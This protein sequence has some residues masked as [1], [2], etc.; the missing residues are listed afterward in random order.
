MKRSTIILILLFAALGAGTWFA[1]RY[2]QKA[3]QGSHIDPDMDFAIKNTDEIYKIFIADRTGRT[4]TLE[5][6][7]SKWLYNKAYIARQTAVDQLLETM[8]K[9]RVNYIPPAASEPGMIKSIAA[10]GIKVEAYDKEGKI[11]KVYYVGGVTNDE[12]GTYVMMEGAEHP[13]VA[14]IPI[15]VGSFRIHFRLEPDE[16]YDR[17]IFEEKPED[18]QFVSVEYPQR[19]SES[20]KLEKKA[21]LEYVVTP[22]FSTTPV[23][24][25]PQKKGTAEA[26]LI[27]FEKLGCEAY[28][29]HSPER[30]SIINLVPFAIVTL[31]NTNGAEKVVKF[32]PVE[33]IDDPNT[34]KT[35]TIRYLTE[36]SWGPFVLTQHKVFGPIFRGYSHF[37]GSKN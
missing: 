24:H 34:K 11:I 12:T 10:E 33:Q 13:Y 17:T 31:K 4:A 23:S 35:L 20:F 26:Y 29:T 22:F 1:M 5:R 32:W 36:C 8:K 25:Q 14:H 27:G 21:A 28:E 2:N 37:Y 3:K 9:M 16:W 19:K 7:G 30:D 6:N 18:I 15:M